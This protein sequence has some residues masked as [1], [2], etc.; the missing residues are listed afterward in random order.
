MITKKLK[1]LKF[2]IV[3][4]SR[5]RPMRLDLCPHTPRGACCR[6]SRFACASTT[7]GHQRARNRLAHLPGSG[8]PRGWKEPPSCA[9]E[10][11]RMGCSSLRL[12]GGTATEALGSARPRGEFQII[13]IIRLPA[14]PEVIPETRVRPSVQPGNRPGRA[15]RVFG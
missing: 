2:W 14:E 9:S 7:L 15:V 1:N 3:T 4:S 8:D 5:L 11:P 12:P 6:A 13:D 10:G